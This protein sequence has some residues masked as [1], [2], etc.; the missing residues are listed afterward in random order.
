MADEDCALRRKP[1]STRDS[2]KDGWNYF[3][4]KVRR[5]PSDNLLPCRAKRVSVYSVVIKI[6][7]LSMVSKSAIMASTRVLICETTFRETPN[8]CATSPMGRSSNT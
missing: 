1:P 7:S 5:M 3:G 6:Q 8:A 2:T 4:W